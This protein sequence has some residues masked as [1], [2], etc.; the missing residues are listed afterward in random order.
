M[1]DEWLRPATERPPAAT[2]S[3]RESDSMS[4]ES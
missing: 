1:A 3:H 2:G 4:S